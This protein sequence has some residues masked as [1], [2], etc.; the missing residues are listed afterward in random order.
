MLLETLDIF[1]VLNII[2]KMQASLAVLVAS[3]DNRV[4][5]EDKIDQLNSYN[6]TIWLEE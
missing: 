6:K 1:R 4:E 2:S 3:Q 5:L